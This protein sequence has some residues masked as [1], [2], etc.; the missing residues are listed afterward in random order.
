M[1][2]PKFLINYAEVPQ[3]GFR[4]KHPDLPLITA[5]SWKDLLKEVAKVF[6]NNN[7]PVGLEF[8]RQIEQWLCEQLPSSQVTTVNPNRSPEVPRSDWPLWAR[9]LAL[10]AKPED[11][12]VGD[13]IAR[14]I[15]PFGGEN[16]KAWYQT[17]FGAS[18]GCV[19][20]QDSF[21]LQYNYSSK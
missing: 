16:F 13:T 3:G 17:A 12:G 9:A 5:P 6:H 7:I 15:G 10:I 19:E 20:R 14:T 4:F 18:C 1:T 11:K 2:E 8:D 21:N